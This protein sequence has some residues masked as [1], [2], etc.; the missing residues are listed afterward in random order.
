MQRLL[1]VEDDF[2]SADAIEEVLLRAGF[3]I[4]IAHSANDAMRAMDDTYSTVIIDLN[5]PDSR[6]DELLIEMRRKFG[7]GKRYGL[8]TGVD[9]RR[10]SKIASECNANFWLTKP[11][12]IRRLIQTLSDKT[13]GGIQ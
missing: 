13:K 2:R 6:G 7:D 5:L 3:D 12:D 1:L 4:G 10:I 9:L 11:I 8:I